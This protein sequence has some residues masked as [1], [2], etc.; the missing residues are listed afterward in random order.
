MTAA[1]DTETKWSPLKIAKENRM[2]AEQAADL[3]RDLAALKGLVM[4]LYVLVAIVGVALA[5]GQRRIARNQME[6]ADLIRK[7]REEIR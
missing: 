5:W 6:L 1:R 3:T 2:I 4:W 7:T